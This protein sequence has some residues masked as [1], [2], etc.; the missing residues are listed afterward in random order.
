MVNSQRE[1]RV[2]SLIPNQTSEVAGEV[3]SFTQRANHGPGGPR[4]PLFGASPTVAPGIAVG[5]IQW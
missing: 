3:I 5:L 4:Q 1:I 2:A